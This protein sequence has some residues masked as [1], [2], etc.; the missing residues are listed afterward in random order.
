MI[1]TAADARRRLP[2]CFDT[3]R[4]EPMFVLGDAA[5]CDI[6]AGNSTSL[7][8]PTRGRSIRCIGLEKIVRQ[9]EDRLSDQ[10]L[11]CLDL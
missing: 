8:L 2:A 5:C 10:M 11:F 6:S 9:F 1:M 7:T 3:P 4:T